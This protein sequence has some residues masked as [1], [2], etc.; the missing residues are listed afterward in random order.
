MWQYHDVMQDILINGYMQ[1]NRTTDRAIKTDYG[2]A[3]RFDMRD[4][5]PAVTTKKLAF[6]MMKAEMIGFLRGYDNAEQF[7]ALGCNWWR[8]DANEN[9]QWLASPHREG[10]GHMGRVYGVQWRRYRGPFLF[11]DTTTAPAGETSPFVLTEDD[12]QYYVYQDEID[13]LQQVLDAIRNTPE[14]RR[15]IMTAW[16]PA[17]LDKMCLPPCHVTYKFMVNVKTKELSM[18]LWQRSCDMFLGVP[19][20]I[21]GGA[22][23]LHLVAKATG[24]L[25]RFMTHH[26]DDAHIYESHV[27]QVEQQLRR[28]AYLHPELDIRC[29]LY[30][31]DADGLAAIEP[32][33]IA[34]IN[35]QHHPAIKAE[36]VTG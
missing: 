9:T 30:G 29:D 32:R 14:S 16:N 1:G 33:D 23:L 11:V 8:K 22:L 13:Q 10:D 24:L 21:A 19:M 6:D 26:L 18:S 31:A 28:G 27:N 15:I 7:A 3:M 4:G 5:F 36:M 34:L 35:Y 25:P 17:E 20:N 2:Y 12:R